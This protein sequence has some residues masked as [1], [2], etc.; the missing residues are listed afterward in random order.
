MGNDRAGIGV[1]LHEMT[2]AELAEKVVWA[3]PV[4][5]WRLDELIEAGYPPTD[6]LVL[7]RREDVDLHVATSLLRNGCTVRTA[8]R[9][10]I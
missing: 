3:D 9:I 1:Y 7:S 6:A 4:R 5:R 10:L 8:L 2:A